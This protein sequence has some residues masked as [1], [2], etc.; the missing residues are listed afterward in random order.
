MQANHNT[1]TISNKAPHVRAGHYR[2]V[3][4]KTIWVNP[5]IVHSK[6][7][8]KNFSTISIAQK[9]KYRKHFIADNKTTKIL[10]FPGSKKTLE[11]HFHTAMENLQPTK[12][13]YFLE[14]FAGS[15]GSFGFLHN[16]IEAK[17]YIIGD[18]NPKLVN[19]YRAVKN[20]PIELIE[21]LTNLENEFRKCLPTDPSVKK[22]LVKGEQ[23]ES[24]L[25]ARDFHKKVRDIFN[26]GRLDI[27]SAAA[28]IFLQERSFNG[29]YKET[30]TGRYGTSFNWYN[31]HINLESLSN[32]IID[33]H[34]TMQE[35]KVI[36]ENLDIFDF[37]KKY[38][39]TDSFI[40]A[41]VP[42][43]G[44]DLKYNKS[45]FNGSL[46]DHLALIEKTKYYKHVLYSNSYHTELL[47][48]FDGYVDFSRKI[49]VN[50]RRTDSKKRR[51]IL[52]Y[53]TNITTAQMNT[54]R[55]SEVA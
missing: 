14:P 51:E 18:N 54:S 28:L 10:K 20:T 7:F 50:G 47:K 46:E 53:R 38:S 52:A 5:T 43:L 21:A 29:V 17:N 9:I 3:A 41:D 19:Y 6:E 31:S 49:E 35:K 34:T 55:T 23:R 11:K 4:N 13:E 32:A 26:E 2:R 40:Y 27:E 37:L 45:A 36:I 33:M 39:S 25:S 30:S 1:K 24:M 42:Y 12:V 16:M 22:G 44:S 15:L 8:Y 48:G